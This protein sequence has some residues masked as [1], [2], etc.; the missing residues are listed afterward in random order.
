MPIRVKVTHPVIELRRARVFT[1]RQYHECG[2]VDPDVC[3]GIHK[4]DRYV[5]ISE[6]RLPVCGKCCDL[7]P[8]DVETTDK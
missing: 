2:W 5:R 8:Y 3:T 6:T 7:Q 1:A 4:G